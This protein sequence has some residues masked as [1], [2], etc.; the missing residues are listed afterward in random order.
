MTSPRCVPLPM[1]FSLGAALM[2]LVGIGGCP[3]M[4]TPPPPLELDGIVG[5]GDVAIALNSAGNIATLTATADEGWQFARFET[6]DGDVTFNPYATSRNSVNDII[7]VFIERA[8]D[9][10]GDGVPDAQDNCPAEPNPDQDDEDEDGVGDACDNCPSV[11]NP[12]QADADGDAEGDACDDDADDDGRLNDDDNCPTVVNVDQAD[13]DG[14]GLG[15][16]CDNCVNRPNPGQ[17]DSDGDAIGDACDD[18]DGDGIFDDDDNCR[19]TPNPNQADG[20]GDD[21]GN[22]C[23]NCPNESNPNQADSDGDGVGDACDNCPAT[24]NPDQADFDANDVG[25]ACDPDID[26]DNVP[27]GSDNCPSFPN[28][29]QADTDGDNEGDACDCDEEERFPTGLAFFLEKDIGRL[30]RINLDGEDRR[31]LLGTQVNDPSNMAFDPVARQVYWTE[32]GTQ[33]G[34]GLVARICPNGGQ[35]FPLVLG[36]AS[37]HSVAVDHVNRFA[38]FTDRGSDFIARV[39]IDNVNVSFGPPTIEIVFDSTE[40][41]DLEGTAVDPI[42]VAL[43]L[44]PDDPKVYWTDAARDTIE[45]SNIDGTGHEI[46]RD[47]T[48]PVR[49]P[50]D[51]AIDPGRN[52]GGNNRTPRLFYIDRCTMVIQ[53]MNLDGSNVRTIFEGEHDGAC[54]ATGDSLQPVALALDTVNL[55]VYFSDERSDTIF[56][57]NYD[58]SEPEVVI[59]Q[60]D[61]G[62]N[63]FDNIRSMVILPPE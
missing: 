42:G 49:I 1:R 28:E 41:G 45:R 53:S 58:G 21:T 39:P 3:P 23:D 32:R 54:R 36:L 47:L 61:A 35:L 2:L 24:A 26:G 6:P 43:D 27:N 10:D 44:D 20:D 12:D 11:A 7:A 62:D 60:E 50:W 19:T 5:Q 56:R 51:I 34:A 40:G 8:P 22:A 25:D 29:D 52:L 63:P 13:A 14:D 37:P 9:E 57:M 18:S 30:N 4:V 55:K 46:I 33:A 16:A 15:D 59:T 17:A 48:G 38:Y 31:V